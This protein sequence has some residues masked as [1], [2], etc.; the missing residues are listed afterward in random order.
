MN[1]GGFGGMEWLFVLLVWAL[2]FVLAIWFIRTLSS[3]AASV[4]DIAVRIESLERAVRDASH[5]REG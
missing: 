5:G 2:P 1:I 4:R 3:I